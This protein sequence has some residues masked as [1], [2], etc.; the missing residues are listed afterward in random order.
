MENTIRMIA[1][2]KCTGCGA[3]CNICPVDAISMR[4]N[5][6][7]FL[8]P[9]IDES[10][11]IHC[12]KCLKTCPVHEPQYNNEQEPS[13]YAI[14]ASDELRKVS[15]SGGVFSLLADWM[16]EK[17]GVVC[18]AAYTDDC[19]GVKQVIAKTPE[20][21]QPLRGSK[22]VQSD[23][24]MIYREMKDYLDKGTPVLF[25]GTPCQ[26]AAVNRVFGGKYEHL[27]TLDLVCHGVPSPLAYEKFIKEKEAEY[28]SKAVHTAFRDKTIKDWEVTSL[29]EF[30]NGQS[31][32]KVRKECEYLN[33]FLSL[34][35]LRKCC[36]TCPFAKLPRQGDMSIA[37]F[38]NVHQLNKSYDDRKGT[39]L[40][41]VNNKK[42]RELCEVLRRRAQLYS[43]A[44]LDFA[45]KN[46]AQIKYSSLH[47]KERNRFYQML[48]KLDRPFTQS[49][50]DALKR[51]F[52]IGYVGWW[53]GQ[54][55]G[56][57]LTNYALHETLVD[58]GKTVLMLEW[59]S[60][61]DKAPS[62]KPDT[63]TR[64]FAKHFYEQSLNCTLKDYDH[65]NWHC[66]T[67]VVGSDQL[68][69]WY[70]N[71]DVG[72]Y[73]YFLDFVDDNHKKIAYS[74]SFGHDSAYYP[75]DMHLKI[76]YLLSRFDAVSVREESGIDI[77]KRKFS[78]DAVQTIDPVFL[79]SMPS[80]E[81]AIALSKADT[82][83]PY[84]LAYILNPTKEKM[85]M[86][87]HAAAEMGLPYKLIV[88]G[89]GDFEQLKKE[90]GDDPNLLANVEIADWLKYF[91][92]A[93][94][95]ITDSFH[96]F[97]FSIIF[98]RNMTVIP[99]KLRG[100]ARFNTMFQLTGLGVRQC[101]SLRKLKHDRPW[102]NP[103][104]YKHIFSLMQPKIDY[105]RD[106]LQHA[107]DYD[108]PIREV[109]EKQMRFKQ[110]LEHQDRI[111]S[112]ET[113]IRSLQ[114]KLA[115]LQSNYADLE[116]KAVAETRKEALAAPEE[117][118]PEPSA[119]DA[120]GS[121]SSFLSKIWKKG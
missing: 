28:G 101:D 105:S 23:T 61:E 103:I 56:S 119:Q 8:F 65:F 31:Y 60:L 85:D 33:A 44:P 32:R 78:A 112:L 117:S 79:C 106:W 50:N 26:V 52:D 72:T 111:N 75:E 67:F 96:G 74:T 92:D 77:C 55:F 107:L 18:G 25:T 99:N 100:M 20:E 35:S 115:A 81:K 45:I 62:T 80:W 17:G 3:C 102:E 97:C 51:K 93:Q 66:K 16:F 6:E 84:V 69:N 64:R 24:G 1:E 14:M 108:P 46:N 30:E 54:N 110:L 109:S 15:S 47:H 83:Q 87:R 63:K 113:E 88:D 86:I 89:Q 37:D 48:G 12:G 38:W 70:S 94:Y 7:G 40:V 10:K 2:T 9:V 73:Y 13:C 95:V 59:P 43:E 19:Y 118:K 53:Y 22:Y 90:T 104:D 71:R 68:W 76:S 49:V 27:Y 82:T 39:S 4:P 98:N 58:M 29:I 11:C 36:G 91:H 120:K 114:E 121:N 116:A 34:L 42:G 41:I 5:D 21:L 57:A